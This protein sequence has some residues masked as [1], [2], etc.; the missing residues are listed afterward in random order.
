ML[1]EILYNEP[2]RCY[3]S[4]IWSKL[5]NKSKISLTVASLV[6]NTMDEKARKN[7]FYRHIIVIKWQKQIRPTRRNWES[8]PSLARLQETSRFKLSLSSAFGLCFQVWPL[9][10]KDHRSTAFCCL[11]ILVRS[12]KTLRKW[13]SQNRHN[14]KI[15]IHACVLHSEKSPWLVIIL[16]TKR[17]KFQ[18]IYSFSYEKTIFGFQFLADIPI[19]GYTIKR[20]DVLE[21]I[22]RGVRAGAR[23]AENKLIFS[24]M[25]I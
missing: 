23:C 10:W 11:S 17:L 7:S 8:K 2:R 4:R 19:P 14:D 25:F 16:K 6:A 3:K 1:T 9:M 13:I 22:I 12:C 15:T 5:H 20:S 18:K 21:F 24:D